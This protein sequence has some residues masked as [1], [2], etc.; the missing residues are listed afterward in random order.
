MIH[1]WIR[2]VGKKG[3][4][5]TDLTIKNSDEAQTWLWD[6]DAVYIGKQFA[7]NNFH[8][9]NGVANATLENMKV[10]TWDGTVFND[11]V[12]VLDASASCSKS[13]VVQFVPDENDSWNREDTA[14]IP[15]MAD[16]PKIHDLYWIK[17]TFENPIDVTTEIKQL[18]YLFTDQ[19]FMSTLDSDIEKYLPSLGQTDYI[20]QILMAS[21]QTAIDLKARGLIIDEGQIIQFDDF[22]VSVAYKTLSLIYFALGP[23]FED[24]RLI[25]IK[26]YNNN[27][28]TRR[29]TIDKDMD[30]KIDQNE[31]RNTIR[32]M[33]R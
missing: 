13:G 33:I 4:V 8:L 2:L 14:D 10:A 15:E 6:F 30:G 31:M 7:F 16:G 5:F 20:K 21:M 29:L 28:K 1:Q 11:A 25:S 18:S 32:T 24:K 12:D 27:L 23:D 9:W 17:V 26:E 19:S 3:A 22:Y